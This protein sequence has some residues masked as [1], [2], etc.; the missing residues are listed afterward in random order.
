MAKT[1][2][3]AAVENLLRRRRIGGL[4]VTHLP[5]IRYLT[6][7]SGSSA[8]ALA[9]TRENFLL[10]DS[11]Y[12]EQARSE[13]HDCTVVPVSGPAWKTLVTL[14]RSARLRRLGFESQSISYDLFWNL[15]QS[16]KGV[17]LSP[18]V[19]VVEELRRVKTPAE[20]AA[21]GRALRLTEQAFRQVLPLIR[22]GMREIELAAELEFR[23]RQ[24]GAEGFSFD[25][26]IASGLR[27][28]F[29]HGVASSKRLQP[30]DPIIMDFGIYLAGYASDFTRT[31]V[32]GK[33]TPE[34]RRAYAAVRGAL[35]ALEDLPIAG[36]SGRW[37]DGVCRRY[38]ARAGL[39]GYFSHSTGHG[40]GLEIH[41]APSL[42][43]HSGD[44]I[45]PNEVFTVEP[46]VYLPGRFG[47]R[48]EDIVWVGEAACHRLNKAGHRLIEL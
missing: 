3:R 24:K 1:T 32:L 16:L 22:P 47:I 11:R 45:R 30:G 23:L 7:F 48:I 17:S 4:I 34:F 28:T 9:T 8:L 36:K 13:V 20:V 27:S 31:V 12:V 43:I 46:G 14:I 18:Q 21:I 39:G 25:T 40:V 41:E 15:K 5:N 38:L 44:A 10:L 2:R 6:G 42:S 26:I 35:E 33:A 37:A 19:S 29:P